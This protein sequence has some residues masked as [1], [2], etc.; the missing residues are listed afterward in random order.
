T[1]VTL[2]LNPASR[3]R[4]FT[5]SSAHSDIEET[6]TIDAHVSLD[7]KHQPSADS[8][9]P[10]D[11]GA[12]GNALRLK[13]SN[14][15]PHHRRLRAA[16]RRTGPERPTGRGH[17]EPTLARLVTPRVPPPPTPSNSLAFDRIEVVEPAQERPRPF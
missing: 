9:R 5:R 12:D 4:S 7:D 16:R 11:S 17:V 14:A 10:M 3:S 6:M 15:G 8:A 13:S 2:L 1:C